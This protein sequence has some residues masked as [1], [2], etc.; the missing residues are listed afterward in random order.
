MLIQ[1]VSKKCLNFNVD[2]VER[3]SVFHWE[4]WRILQRWFSSNKEE[5]KHWTYVQSTES[6]EKTGVNWGSRHAQVLW[7]S[8]NFKMYIG[9]LVHIICNEYFTVETLLFF[10]GKANQYWYHNQEYKVFWLAFSFNIFIFHE[11]DILIS[12]QYNLPLPKYVFGIKY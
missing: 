11:I 10:N 5:T 7:A 12:N 6:Y 8:N 4:R 2:D 9:V 3:L 1:D